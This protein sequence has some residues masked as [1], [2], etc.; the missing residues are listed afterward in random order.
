MNDME[1]KNN[2]IVIFASANGEVSFEVK[3]ENETVWLSLNQIAGLFE[4][5]KS[6]ISRHI[7]NIFEERELSKET[8]VAKNATVQT[9]GDRE[10]KRYIE[11][12]NLDLI[13]SVGYRVNSKKATQFRIWANKI[14][15]DYLIKGYAINQKKLIVQ[16]NAFS[17]LQKAI[18]FIREKSNFYALKGKTD[19]LLKIIDDYAKS[20]TLLYEYDRGEI[21][22]QKGSQVKFDLTYESCT[23]VIAN[24][25]DKL[26]EKGQAGKLFGKEIEGRFKSIIGTIYQT[27]DQTELYQSLEE[28][29]ANLLYLI[30]KDHP[31]NDGNKRSASLLFVYFLDANHKLFRESGERKIVEDT[32]ATLALLIAV[33]DPRDKE[34]MVRIV[35]NLLK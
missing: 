34:V 8:T 22:I 5:D 26:L 4:R 35:M 10:I 14:L 3:L 13:L 9:E 32:L 1:S 33:S 25:K 27:F 21:S 15:K 24:L 16:A 30:I 2:Q 6:V 23:Q 19:A 29:A 31:F 11:F 7:R 12:Y 18:N 17:E 20:F 28:K